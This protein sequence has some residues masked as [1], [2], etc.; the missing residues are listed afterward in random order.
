MIGWQ[1]NRRSACVS[2]GICV[3]LAVSAPLSIGQI[4]M[5]ARKLVR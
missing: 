1:V 2:N 5:R 3:G 4:G